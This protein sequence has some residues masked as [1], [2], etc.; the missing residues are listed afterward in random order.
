MPASD[1]GKYWKLQCQVSLGLGLHA[2]NL[3]QKQLQS[4]AGY[5]AHYYASK[6]DCQLPKQTAPAITDS[7]PLGF[8]TT[9][10]EILS[11]DDN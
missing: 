11:R 3:N 2:A 4:P 6:R 8:E 5:L 7:Q 9:R 10:F 1:Y